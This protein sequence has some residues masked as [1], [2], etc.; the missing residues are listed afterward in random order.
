MSEEIKKIKIENIHFMNSQ[1][2]FS[3]LEK[4]CWGLNEIAKNAPMKPTKIIKERYP[5]ITAEERQ[6]YVKTHPSSILYLV[7]DG[8]KYSDTFHSINSEGYFI[9]LDKSNKLVLVSKLNNLYD[10]MGMNIATDLIEQ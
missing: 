4:L 8:G 3:Y 1:I 7:I 10:L 9:D 2:H 5:G 6:I